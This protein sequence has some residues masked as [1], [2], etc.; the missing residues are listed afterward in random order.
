[1]LRSQ[2]EQRRAETE[3]LKA[4]THELARRVGAIKERAA[5]MAAAGVED[6]VLEQD[7]GDGVVGE[8]RTKPVDGASSGDAVEAKPDGG[9]EERE[10]VSRMDQS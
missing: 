9:T 6:G 3:A 5:L 2:L 1:M 8:E 10:D 4:K 7:Q